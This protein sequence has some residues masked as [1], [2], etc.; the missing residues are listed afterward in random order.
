MGSASTSIVVVVSGGRRSLTSRVVRGR[1]QHTVVRWWWVMSIT[2]SRIGQ[3]RRLLLR[4]GSL[5][6]GVLQGRVSY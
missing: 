4:V 1:G 3:H 2:G 5:L 6:G